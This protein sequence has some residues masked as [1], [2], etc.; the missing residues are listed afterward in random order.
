[1]NTTES[2]LLS[3]DGLSK[4]LKRWSLRSSRVVFTNGCFDVLHLGHLHTLQK[5]RELG[6]KL[7]VGLNSDASVKRLKGESRPVKD[8]ATRAALLCAFS[9]VDLVVLFD[10]DTPYQLIEC[11]QPDV[12]VKG[13]DWSKE[14]I[15]GSDV[16][17]KK[18]GS[19]E[20]IPYLEGY[21][22]TNLINKIKSEQQNEL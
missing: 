14:Q 7:I 19:V 10:E 11:I 15:I 17:L 22:S 3:K 6:D 4:T 5:A 20:S 16:V 1:M 13:G 8:Q 9:F 18:G 12:L 21:S 2:K